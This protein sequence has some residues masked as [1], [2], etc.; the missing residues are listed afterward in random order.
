MVK[1]LM[2]ISFKIQFNSKHM[3]NTGTRLIAMFFVGMLLLPLFSKAQEA[4]GAKDPESMLCVGKHW[5]EEEGKDFLQQMAK[6]YTTSKEWNSR[7]KQI[8]N[9]I[10]KGTDL[11]KFPKKNP[12][13]PIMGEKRVYE[14]Y[15]VQNV[16][17]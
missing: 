14:G 11:E 16:A 2:T 6:T 3:I 10:L 4:V 15:Q 12:L 8:R 1:I 9:Q 17:F 13:N 5:T 7:A